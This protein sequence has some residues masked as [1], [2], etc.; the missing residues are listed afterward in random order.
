[1]EHFQSIYTQWKTSLPWLSSCKYFF[2][3]MQTTTGGEYW[4]WG[5]Q[6][7]FGRLWC[8]QALRELPALWCLPHSQ[9]GAAPAGSGSRKSLVHDS[10]W[11]SE[12]ARKGG[13]QLM[14]N[15]WA[16]TVWSWCPAEDS[17][18]GSAKILC[19]H[20][21]MTVT[22]SRSPSL[23]PCPLKTDPVISEQQSKGPTCPSCIQFKSR[24]AVSNEDIILWCTYFHIC[25]SFYP[26]GKKALKLFTNN[27]W[28]SFQQSY[29]TLESLLSPCNWG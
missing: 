11:A 1:M 27:L 20:Q 24:I 16:Q 3:G 7:T 13:L 8:R 12:G 19:A 6:K 25:F 2:E 14:R 23:M 15:F 10:M 26:T 22:R 9:D 4:S 21:T 29:L 28:W 18:C 17:Y 5:E